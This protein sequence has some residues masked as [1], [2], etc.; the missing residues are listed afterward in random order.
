MALQGALLLATL[1]LTITL[2]EFP[3]HLW[4][5][6]RIGCIQKRFESIRTLVAH[7]CVIERKYLRE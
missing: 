3:G 5:M 6:Q 7:I 2:Q 4:V 1:W